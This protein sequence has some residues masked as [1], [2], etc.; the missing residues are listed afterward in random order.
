MRLSV[1]FSSLVFALAISASLEA[2]IV[3]RTSD[4]AKNK[5]NNRVDRKIDQG[6]DKGLDSIE[7]L[8]KKKDKKKKSGGDTST[9][10]GSDQT[11]E[12]P[13]TQNEDAAAEAMMARIFG[14]GDVTLPDSYSFDHQVDMKM[15]SMD[16]KGKQE[17]SQEMEMLFS[18]ASPHF[19]VRAKVDGHSSMTVFDMESYQMVALM[20]MS[21]Q[22]MAMTMSFDPAL[23]EV[24]ETEESPEMAFTKTG[25]TRTILGYRCE[26]Y[27]AEDEDGRYE[28]WVT[29][30]DD[31]NIFGAF[32]AMSS[33]NAKGKSSSTPYPAGMTMEMKS[34][35]KNGDSMLLEVVAVNKNKKQTISTQGYQVMSMGGR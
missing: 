23:Y 3:D 24:E 16:K 14:G 6:I 27:V 7:G 22:K 31:F 2:Q 20:D 15:T 28:F 11:T 33:A 30:D 4:R 29:T 25:R 32:S 9:D 12:A 10:E 8:F 1:L 18:D 13:E 19:G 26:E 17:S 5:A 21:G 35:E 34:T